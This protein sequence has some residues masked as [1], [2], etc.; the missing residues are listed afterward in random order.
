MASSY[1]EEDKN[2][3]FVNRRQP[4]AIALIEKHKLNV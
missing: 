1:Q 3:Q 2:V 4:V